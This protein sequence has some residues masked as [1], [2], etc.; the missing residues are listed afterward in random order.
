MCN[1]GYA[2]VPAGTPVTF[3]N[4]DPVTGEARKLS[5]VFYTPDPVA[6]RCCSAFTTVI[7]VDTAGLNQLYAVFNDNGSTSPLKLPNATLPELNYINNTSSKTNFQFHVTAIPPDATLQPGDTLQLGGQAEPGIVSSY[8]WSTAE[9]LNCTD[10]ANPYFIAE[11]KVYNSTK[12]VIATSSYGC[13]DTG[14][15][16]LHIPPADD[17]QVKIDKL[18]CAGTDSLHAAFT[19]C[20]NFK[21]GTVPA[22]LKVSFYDADPTEANANLLGPVFSTDAA[23]PDKCASYAGFFKRSATG[24]VFAIVNENRQIGTAFTTPLHQ[25]AL[26]ENNKDTLSLIP[27]EV[28]I[29]PAD[30]SISRQSGVQFNPQTTGGEA[31]T[32]K[33]EPVD[34]LSCTDCSSPVATPDRSIEYHLTVQNEYACAATGTSYLKIFSGGLVN[35]PNGFTPNN[36]GR[37]DVFY[38]LGGKDVKL[39]KDLSIFNRWGQKIF[40]VADVSPNDPRFGWNGL[41]NGKPAGTGAYVYF[42]IIAFEDGSTHTYKGTITLIR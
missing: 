31:S 13:V 38:I 41:L 12:Q 40:Q 28:T 11:N 37:N 27:F 26:Y 32:Y 6:G 39:I 8:V 18:D 10:C 20:N 1:N 4:A 3:Y 14:V 5:P 2:P 34:Y 7:D 16:I 9:D 35:I 36:D 42:V 33:W 25:E 21:R 22:G 29:Y 17:F 19:I 15:A 24:Q 23:T 30:T